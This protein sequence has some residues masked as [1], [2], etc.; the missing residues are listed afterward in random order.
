MNLEKVIFGFFVVLAL[1]LNVAFVI[2]E[3]DDPQ[4]HSVWILF[5][6]IVVNLIATVLKIGDRSHIGALLLAT[7]LVAD[8]QLI[9]CAS[10]WTIA[11]QVLGVV[12]TEVT[13]GIVSLAA[14]ALVANVVSVT[15]VVTDSLISGR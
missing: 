6:A 7:A 5:T 9:A 14:G 13:V 1:T 12:S 4:H 11:N 3:I 15:M 8:L 10:V 2:G